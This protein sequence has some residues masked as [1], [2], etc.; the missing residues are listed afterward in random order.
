MGYGDDMLKALLYFAIGF[1]V[2]PFIVMYLA[3]GARVIE[4]TI[5]WVD[6]KLKEL[7]K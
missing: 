2:V 3:I 7:F 1:A 5:E 4:Y 6:S